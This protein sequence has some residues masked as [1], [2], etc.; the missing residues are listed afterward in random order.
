MLY[1]GGGYIRLTVEKLPSGDLNIHVNDRDNHD[2]SHF[3]DILYS[4]NLVQHVNQPTHE[5]GHTLDL[6]NL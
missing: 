3:M 2:A 6:I 1:G 4:Y 5:N